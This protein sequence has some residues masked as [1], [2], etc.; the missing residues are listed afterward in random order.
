MSKTAYK[1][2]SPRSANAVIADSKSQTSSDG[3]RRIVG[4]NQKRALA[5]HRFEVVRC[6]TLKE[7][8]NGKWQTISI[9][10]SHDDAMQFLKGS[11]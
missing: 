6:Y 4:R 9:Q 8:V 1:V 2:S 5:N 11:A 3:L 7:R 10:R